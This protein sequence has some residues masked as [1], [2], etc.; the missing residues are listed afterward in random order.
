M[1]VAHSCPSRTTAW[2]AILLSIAST[3]VVGE[4]VYA[5]DSSDT[6]WAPVVLAERQGGVILLPDGRLK[7]FVSEGTGEENVY[8]NYS[9]VSSDGGVTWGDRQFE[10]EGPRAN[11]PLLDMDGEYHVFPMVARLEEG[12]REIAVTYFIDIWHVKTS[13]GGTVWD[14]P[15]R[16][17]EGYVGS[18]NNVTQLSTGRII[19]P[20]AKWIGK[21]PQGPPTGANVTTC[22]Y[23][24]DG[25][26]TWNLSPSE[27][28][29]PCYTDF[30][31]SGYGACEPV[32]IELK[33]G[34]VYMLA[35]TETGFLYD[36][37]S[38]DGVHWEPLR[39]SRFLSTD[40]PAALL[41]LPDDRILLFWNGCEKPPRHNGD[42]V[43][44]GRDALHAAISSDECQTWQ[45]FREVYLD[46]TRNESPQ[47]TGDR[48]TAYPMPYL[49]PDGKVIVMAGQ[50]RS[51]ATFHFDPNWL[52]ETH[53]EDDFS[54][55]LE[56]W[57]VFKH[58]GPAERWWRD[59]T[60]G[61]VLVEHPEKPGAKALHIR[62]P[63]VKPGDGAVWNFPMGR[64]GTLTIK[65]QLQEG[66]DGAVISLLDRF[67]N[68]TDETG[69]AEA[70]VSLPIQ[71]DGHVSL[72]N[73]LPIGE[74]CVLRF[75]WDIDKRTC[76]VDVNGQSE[77]HLK[78][79]YR[80]PLGINYVRFRSTA[81]AVDDS[82]LLL[83]SVTADIVNSR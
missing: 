40:G 6:V 17:F 5:G 66:F 61:P 15:K 53:R 32:I 47:K 16:I 19:V 27:L 28:T 60:Q 29:A 37:Y 24:D 75:K 59:R 62:R 43:Y 14:A 45:G 33:D 74:W 10:Y 26:E 55:G 8:K 4:P 52:L 34:R 44:G 11:L 18:I 13:N 48:G 9:L 57:T 35:R 25:G 50:G 12:K 70:I 39:P 76:T 7:R 72:G 30:N 31:G 69:D 83:E 78:P 41:R 67:F 3:A 42:G 68:P 65:L 1:M 80:E 79:H 38:N 71:S 51:G 58:F 81:D 46:P 64:Q 54:K 63:D 77:L 73:A 23:S 82:G 21:Q 22:V 36:S 49:A 2:L 20:F 56:G